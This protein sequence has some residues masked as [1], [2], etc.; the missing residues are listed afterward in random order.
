MRLLVLSVYLSVLLQAILYVQYFAVQPHVR[1][2]SIFLNMT[3]EDFITFYRKL[4]V[5][6]RFQLS[7]CRCYE[8]YDDLSCTHCGIRK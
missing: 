4:S 8:M 1:S 3:L 6:D 5:R 7:L 2:F